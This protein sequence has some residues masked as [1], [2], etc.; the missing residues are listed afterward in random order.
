M[1]MPDVIKVAKRGPCEQ[2]VP[3]RPTVNIPSQPPPVRP[4]VQAPFQPQGQPQ[5]TG[6]GSPVPAQ[7]RQPHAGKVLLNYI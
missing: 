4:F 6:Q 1:T 7:Q 5:P 2:V 3:V